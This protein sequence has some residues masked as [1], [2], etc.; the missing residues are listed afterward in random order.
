MLTH[1]QI[2]RATKENNSKTPD[3]TAPIFFPTIQLA[4]LVMYT[5]FQDS[6]YSSS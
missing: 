4:I 1:T 3:P 5:K 2:A 6:R